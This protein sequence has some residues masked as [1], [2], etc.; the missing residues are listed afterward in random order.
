MKNKIIIVLLILVIAIGTFIG[1]RNGFNLGKDFRAS[2][3]LNIQFAE[4]FEIADVEEIAREVFGNNIYK[5]EYLNEFKADVVI[6]LKEV[7]NEQIEN[8]ENKLK[9]KYTSFKNEEEIDQSH[10]HEIIQ[11]I[12][13]PS[14]NVYDLVQIYINPLVITAIL[15][16]ICMIILF[17]KKGILKVVITALCGIIGSLALYISAV[18]ILRI[19]VNEWTISSGILIY[20]I[21]V[22]GTTIYLKK[23][24]KQ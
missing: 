9:E 7:S 13:I 19:P 10:I 21:S 16:I 22:F 14:I 5:I 8:L 23:E 6:S 15:S 1:C 3:K 2:K 17:Y 4:N 11:I 20:M 18:A 24:V 12:D